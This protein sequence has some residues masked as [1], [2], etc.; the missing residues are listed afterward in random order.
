MK[1]LILKLSI[2]ACVLGL[3]TDVSAKYR[4]DLNGD[5]RV[6]LADMVYLAKAIKAGSTDVAL[7]INI[8][9]SVDDY[10][11]QKLADIIISGT[12]TEEGGLN[13]G[14]GGWDDTG[15]DYGGTVK[16]L[17]VTSRSSQDIQLYL[18]DA[19]SEDEY[20]NKSIEFGFKGGTDTPC[21]FLIKMEIPDLDF[22]S[23]RM[24]VLDEYVLSNHNLFG[25]PS[26]VWTEKDDWHGN[27]LVFIIF[28]SDLV[29]MSL[30]E[31][32][33]GRIYYS[34]A[35]NY[36]Q[37]ARFEDCQVLFDGDSEV[38]TLPSHWSEYI[39]FSNVKLITDSFEDAPCDIYTPSGVLVRKGI[40]PSDV[41]NLPPGLYIVNQ[42]GKT[43]KL[44]K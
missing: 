10:D 5:D 40:I 27:V 7:D 11:L 43:T 38:V 22:N 3:A 42:R 31:G 19:R 25:S 17:V 1:K 33:L 15:E 28:S 13:V 18:Q 30:S 2:L 6:D 35:E 24:V 16:A 14:I 29:P 21:A 36:H 44:L 8:S 41:D 12:L 37:S 34:C 4:G 20:G 39:N 23:N 32:K 9:G 26:I